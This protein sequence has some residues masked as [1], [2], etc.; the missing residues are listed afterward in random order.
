MTP[1]PWV[2]LALFVVAVLYSSV[3]HGG[4][5]GYL[6]VL[7]FTVLESRE[8]A[9]L[10]LVANVLVAGVSFVAYRAAKHFDWSLVWPYVLASMPFAFL[11]ASLKLSPGAYNWVV[12]GVLV[13]AAVRLLVPDSGRGQ[14]PQPGLP[15]R[16][17]LGSGMGLIS[18]IV[19][20]GGG[21]F[22]S[23][24][25]V[26]AGWADAKRAGA[27]SAAFIVANSAAGLIPRWSDLAALRAD[28]IGLIGAA[29]AGSLLGAWLGTRKMGFGTLKTAL[30]VVLVFAA[31]K[32]G[33]K[34]LGAH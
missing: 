27:A 12:A 4:A 14:R 28:D 8:V 9:I 29:V 20:V 34:A 25:L 2:Y 23:P 11:G 16:F 3:G 18:G 24:L 1:E 13:F 31:I 10:A 6:A 32:L 15:V 17:G 21:I 19:G 22:L 7:S 30:A 5:S 33:M 26:L